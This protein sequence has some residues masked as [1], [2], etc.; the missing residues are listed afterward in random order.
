[1][2]NVRHAHNDGFNLY[3]Y[4]GTATYTR[5][6]NPDSVHTFATS[7]NCPTTPTQLSADCT[8]PTVSV[9]GQADDQAL[10]DAAV[11]ALQAAL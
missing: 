8:T 4:D 6:G 5:S 3:V 7:C 10:L 1:M 9:S 11:T 2:G